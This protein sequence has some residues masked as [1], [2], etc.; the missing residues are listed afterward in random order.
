MKTT[1]VFFPSIAEKKPEVS[2]HV[3]IRGHVFKSEEKQPFVAS[4]K[5]VLG[6]LEYNASDDTTKCHE[7]GVWFQFLGS[8]IHRGHGIS[9]AK[10]NAS[11]GLGRNTAISGMGI[12]AKR[13]SV[14]IREAGQGRGV[15]DKQFIAA[16][17]AG[18]GKVKGRAFG[19]HPVE[20]QNESNRCA[21]QLLYQ[22]QRL[23]ATIGRTPGRDALAKAGINPHVLEHR[24]GNVPAAMKACGLDPNQSGYTM[25]PLPRGFP[26]KAEIKKRFNARMPWPE[27][28]FKPQTK[29][30]S[31][32]VDA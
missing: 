32:L 10:Y 4:G 15:S 19:P 31:S 21:A 1:T 2:S 12:R 27:D 30:G 24:F 3:I 16:R 20:V 26:S 11:H 22:V 14:Q 8:H 25:T 18:K 7:C 23:A 5:S 9:R 29:G 28:Y 13:R 6:A 17:A